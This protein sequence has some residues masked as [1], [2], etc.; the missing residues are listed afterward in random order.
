[1]K[2]AVLCSQEHERKG[3]LYETPPQKDL[4]S[5]GLER[6]LKGRKKKDQTGLLK[7]FR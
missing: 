7:K 4:R 2:I 6:Y 1:V 5:E 3:L